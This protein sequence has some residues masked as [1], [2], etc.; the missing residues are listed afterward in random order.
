MSQAVTV[1]NS[2]RRLIGGLIHRL[3]IGGCVILLCLSPVG[4]QGQET[5][6]SS[7]TASPIPPVYVDNLLNGLRVFIVERK[8]EPTITLSLLV[9]NGSVFDLARKT[10]TAAVMVRAMLRGARDLS[11][12]TIAERLEALGARV[13]V[14]VTVDA[15]HILLEA[16]SRG[17]TELIPLMARFVSFPTFA[18]EEVTRVKQQ[19]LAE[20]RTRR[21]DPAA[22]ADEEFLKALYQPHPYGRPPE[23]TEEEVAALSPYD[24]L[25]HHRRFFIAN[26]ASLVIISDLSP[27]ALMPLVRPYFGAFLKGDPVPA[28]F[29]PPSAHTGIT[30]KVYDRPDLTESHIRIGYFG[31]EKFNEDYFPALILGQILTTDRLPRLIGSSDQR[32][33]SGCRF[34]LRSFK[35]LFLCQAAVPGAKT[36]E[37]VAGLLRLFAEIR[38]HGVTEAE[39]N[40]AASRLIEHYSSRMTQAREI[41]RELHRIELYRLG[42]DYPQKFRER[43]SRVT[44]T[45]VKRVADKYLPSSTA[46]IAVV[47][48]AHSFAENLKSLGAVEIV[49]APPASKP[50]E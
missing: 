22:R 7:S 17:A 30:I 40:A 43:L 15:M 38:T 41:A 47:G 13:D 42:R 9:E 19:Y 48:P 4:G 36:V 18:A 25:R 26:K 24:L 1:L 32:A 21:T 33:A 29:L 2:A 14:S 11:G 5:P 23:G 8:G 34:E 10:G 16:P 44:P 3:L 37:T 45:D 27:Q 20:L 6:T 35:G 39:V 12:Q 49:N 28:S 46:I 31:L 50:G